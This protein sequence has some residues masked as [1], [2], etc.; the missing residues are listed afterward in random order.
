VRL[1][2]LVFKALLDFKDFKAGKVY[3]DHKELRVLHL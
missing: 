3:K 2:Q 1:D